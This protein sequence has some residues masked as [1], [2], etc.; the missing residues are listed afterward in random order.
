MHELPDKQQSGG[1]L[2]GVRKAFESDWG[3]LLTNLSKRSTE[4]VEFE[5]L[6]GSRVEKEAFT[7]V[8]A[9]TS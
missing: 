5:S 3:A 1:L 6:S 2:R 9:N 7:G 4:L 8:L